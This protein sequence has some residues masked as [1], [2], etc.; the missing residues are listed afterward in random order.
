MNSR[1]LGY[2]LIDYLFFL[3]FFL[4]AGAF[5]SYPHTTWVWLAG[6]LVMSFIGM[7]FKKRLPNLSWWM[8]ALFSVII[9]VPFA[10]CIGV[11]IFPV[12][13]LMIVYPVM[14]YRGLG[15]TSRR[16][17][18]MLA[19]PVL[20][21]G[22]FSTYFVAYLLF[23]NI[24]PLTDY[25][26]VLT[27]GGVIFV[28]GTLFISNSERLKQATLSQAKSPRINQ[29][30]KRQ[31][32]VYLVLTAILILILSLGSSV[33]KA[34]L[35]VTSW[36]LNLL[37]N[38]REVE[39]LPLEETPLNEG[40]LGE[41]FLGE[42]KEPSR[43]WEMLQA[44]MMYTVMIGL[45]VATLILILLLFKKT[46]E[47]MLKAYHSFINVLKK[48]GTQA[49]DA[50]DTL[51]YEEEKENLFDFSTWRKERRNQ[52]QAFRSRLFGKRVDWNTLSNREK[53]RF[54][55]RNFIFRQT[56]DKLESDTPSEVLAKISAE[57]A[58][59]QEKLTALSHAYERVRY[60]DQ[61][62][63]DEEVEEISKLIDK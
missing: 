63:S 29:T 2:L 3:P 17:G 32:K 56:D 22:G 13:F 28:I 25:L 36:L 9:S 61:E 44:V 41:M 43:F 37:S 42:A 16:V 47:A 7:I 39:E 40:G 15:Y 60:S 5:L 19:L 51:F 14:F 50:E 45:A 8:Y 1:V 11:E 55:Y 26:P 34:L 46:R 54:I 62:I 10:L 58:M 38:D 33:R 57:T 30:I 4:L 52:V 23:R 59:N 49:R 31:N 18:E 48:Q 35:S 27:V 6:F 53:V 21:V 20:W 24:A 12:L